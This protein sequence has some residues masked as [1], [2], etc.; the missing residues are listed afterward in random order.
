VERELSSE[1]LI[2][3]A[4]NHL[5]GEIQLPLEELTLYGDEDENDGLVRGIAKHYDEDWVITLYGKK[6]P[7]YS[8]QKKKPD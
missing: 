1:H 8:G 2:V 4:R 6:G 5:T 3:I 7:D